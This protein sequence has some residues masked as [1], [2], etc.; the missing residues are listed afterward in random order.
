MADGAIGVPRALIECTGS[1]TAALLLQAVQSRACRQELGPADPWFELDRA[2]LTGSVGLSAWETECALRALVAGGFVATRCTGSAIELRVMRAPDAQRAGF[3]TGEP[4][5]DPEASVGGVAVWRAHT[6]QAGGVNAGLLLAFVRAESAATCQEN[7]WTEGW[8]ALDHAHLE[9][10]I[11]LSR[12]E[13]D[14]ARLHLR[15]TG[16]LQEWRVRQP[17]VTLVRASPDEI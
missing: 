15:Q 1:V 2:D 7:P 13:A 11:C 17:Q 6:A 12:W 14:R 3:D 9:A 10:A 16:L 5:P 8:F 4:G